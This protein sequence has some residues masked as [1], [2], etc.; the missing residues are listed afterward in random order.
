MDKPTTRAAVIGDVVGSRAHPARARLQAAVESALAAVDDRL[1]AAQPSRPTIGDEFQ[2]LYPDLPAAL[3]M[4]LLVRLLLMDEADVRFGIGWGEL[5]VVDE[6]SA[7]FRQDGPAWWAAR[8][9]LDRLRKRSATPGAP[10]GLRTVLAV[11]R[12]PATDAPKGWVPAAEG[13]INALL[14]CRDEIVSRMDARDARLLLGLIDGRG[15]AEL[16]ADEG[17]TQPAI[18]QRLHRNGSYAVLDAHRSLMGASA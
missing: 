13:P 7:P 8:A 14:V 3:T 12:D 11:H 18:S 15:Q 17:V 10:R 4:T 5:T 1:P 9:A 6:A 16:A 2:A